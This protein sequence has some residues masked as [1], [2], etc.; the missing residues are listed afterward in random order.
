MYLTTETRRTINYSVGEDHLLTW[1]EA[2]LIDRKANGLAD[3]TIH[4]Y[5]VKLKKFSEY[6]EAQSIKNIS[7]IS[8]SLIRQYMLFLEE[9]GHNPGGKHGIFRA[10][11]AFLYWYEGETDLDDWKNPIRKVK[12]P[13]VPVEPLEPVS[14]ENVSK[15]INT[16]EKGTF[17][18]DRDVAIL[19]CLLDTGARAMEFLN[20]DLN[21]INLMNGD[22]LIRCGKGKKPRTV[23]IG[24]Q[25]RKAVRRYLRHRRDDCLAL[26]VT[27]PR[28]ESSRLSYDGLR[29]VLTRRAGNAGVEE[30]NI[31]DFRRAFA[32]SMLRNG[33][34]VFTLAKLMGH[35]GITVL[36]RYLKQTNQDTEAAHHRA[37]PVDNAGW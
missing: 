13:K 14:I 25:S 28:F 32:L 30:P 33:T 36:Q 4:F 8:P 29:E 27:H 35:E 10:I 16:C 17:T 1:M 2:F 3:G 9:A 12:A 24:K 31:H 37:G 11:R 7:Q 6:C 19:M 20:I 26:W 5:Q 34:D 15:M 22:I 18:G 23:F 21:D